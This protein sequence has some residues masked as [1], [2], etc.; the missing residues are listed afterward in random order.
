MVTT[1]VRN[2]NSTLN[3][4]DHEIKEHRIQPSHVRM[5]KR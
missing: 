3:D 4:C 2:C 1:N 5:F